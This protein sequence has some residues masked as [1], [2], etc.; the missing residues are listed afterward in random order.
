MVAGSRSYCAS[1][2]S[3]WRARVARLREWQPRGRKYEMNVGELV[4]TGDAAVD[5][6]AFQQRVAAINQDLL[7]QAFGDLMQVGYQAIA[8]VDEHRQ[9][10]IFDVSRRV[11]GR[12]KVTLRIKPSYHFSG[13]VLQVRADAEGDARILV[14]RSNGEEF[15][16]PVFRYQVLFFDPQ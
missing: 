8:P 3:G 4:V 6:D 9:M 15:D 13:S 7:R 16:Q 10:T 14:R 1:L 11:V 12:E 5:E 2:V